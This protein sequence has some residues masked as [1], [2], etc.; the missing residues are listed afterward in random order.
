MA[1]FL[2]VFEHYVFCSCSSCDN[3]YEG[4]ENKAEHVP[5]E[6]RLYSSKET[7]EARNSKAAWDWARSEEY[8]DWNGE[9]TVASVSLLDGEEEIDAPAPFGASILERT[10]CNLKRGSE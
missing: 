2:V 4:D 10:K 8:E 3:S 9:K 6:K 5:V 7:V 1:K